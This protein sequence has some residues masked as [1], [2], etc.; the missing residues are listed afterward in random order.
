MNEAEKCAQAQ[1]EIEAIEAMQNV[2]KN[3]PRDRMLRVF[4]AAAALHGLDQIVRA[5]IAEA[6]KIEA[7]ANWRTV[8]TAPTD[9][10]EA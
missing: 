3:M 10:G 8:S 2:L 5:A 7:R 4:A 1:A 9:Q 6:D